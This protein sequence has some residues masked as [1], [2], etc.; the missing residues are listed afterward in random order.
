MLIPFN[1]CAK[2]RKYKKKHILRLNFEIHMKW[3]RKN[4]EKTRKNKLWQ[5]WKTLML[6][7]AQCL[8]EKNFIYKGEWI[9]SCIHIQIIR[10]LTWELTNEEPQKIVIRHLTFS[11][12]SLLSVSLLSVSCLLMTVLSNTLQLK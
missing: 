12:F 7:V 2:Y 1:I 11:S 9:S 6:T 10:L 8:T 3:T 5:Q 4:L